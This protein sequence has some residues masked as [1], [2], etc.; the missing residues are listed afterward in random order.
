[1]GNPEEADAVKAEE[2]DAPPPYSEVDNLA[3]SP[4]PAPPQGEPSSSASAPSASNPAPRTPIYTKFPPTLNAYYQKKVTRTFHLGATVD[5]PLFA[6]KVHTGHTSN[7]EVELYDGPGDTAPLLAAARRDSARWLNTNVTLPASPR[8]GLPASTE[9]MKVEWSWGK[10]GTHRFSV[11]VDAGAASGK[12]TWRREAFEWRSSRGSEVRELATQR[13]TG[14]KLVR[15][16]SGPQGGSGGETAQRSEGVTSDGK[17]IVAVW[18]HNTPWNATKTFKME[19]RGSAASGVLGER[20]EIMAV[21][22]A[23]RLWYLDSEQGF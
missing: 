10:G 23:L 22:T 15:L 19:F 9:P 17:E 14:W 16:E 2:L 8:S 4:D 1:M 20:W 21:V 7:P 13:S 11:E 3:P 6:V 12:P 5:K 18:A